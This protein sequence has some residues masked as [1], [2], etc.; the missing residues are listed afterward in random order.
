MENTIL[1]DTI[2][3]L[4][5]RSKNEVG[6]RFVDYF[7]PIPDPLIAVISSAIVLPPFELVLT[8]YPLGSRWTQALGNRRMS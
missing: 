5:F 6:I 4:P 7:N 8:L 2:L 3:I 1:R